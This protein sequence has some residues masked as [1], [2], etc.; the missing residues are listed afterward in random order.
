MN[1]KKKIYVYIY[2]L[3]LVK[4]FLCVSETNIFSYGKLS[5]GEKSAHGCIVQEWWRE[6]FL[7]TFAELLP[8][9]NCQQQ[10]RL[11]RVNA[12]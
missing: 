1:C 2:L 4:P 8:I 9:R 12:P 11:P 7:L 10:R 3:F 5:Y 6:R